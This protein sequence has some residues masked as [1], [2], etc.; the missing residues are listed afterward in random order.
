MY[1]KTFSNRVGL[2]LGL[3][4]WPRRCPNRALGPKLLKGT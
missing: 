3:L 1:P 2:A 4:H